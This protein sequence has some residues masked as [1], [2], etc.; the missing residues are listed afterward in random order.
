[1]RVLACLQV[2]FCSGYSGFSGFSGLPYLT[3]LTYLLYSS[4]KLW[5]VVEDYGGIADI[6]K[7]CSPRDFFLRKNHSQRR[8][9]VRVFWVARRGSTEGLRLWHFLLI[10]GIL[11]ASL[12]SASA[13]AVTA[14]TASTRLERNE[15]RV[16]PD[17]SRHKYLFT[18]KK[19]KREKNHDLDNQRLPIPRPAI[20]MAS[21]HHHNPHL[22]HIHASRRLPPL[23]DPK[24]NSPQR[25]LAHLRHDA[26]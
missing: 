6:R 21:N 14:A 15:L 17:H 18:S 1:M 3:L 24:K 7:L 20:P 5:S 12:A 19:E 2:C 23:L 11:S 4:S 13:S 8:E 26:V 16:R 9:C 25:G 10:S 22:H